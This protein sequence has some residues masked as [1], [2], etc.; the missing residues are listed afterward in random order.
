MNKIIFILLILIIFSCKKE[1]ETYTIVEV[2]VN[3]ISVEGYG[4]SIPLFAYWLKDRKVVFKSKLDGV[5]VISP[6][7]KLYFRLNG[8]NIIIDR[9][10][11]GNNDIFLIGKIIK[12]SHLEMRLEGINNLS[13]NQIY[14]LRAIRDT[15]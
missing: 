2:R 10:C 3:T 15:D 12:K 14:Y 8:S 6:N 11:Y 1:N 13:S 4:T 7:C 9:E 5:I